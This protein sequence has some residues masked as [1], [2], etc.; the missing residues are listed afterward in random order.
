M[1][2][3]LLFLRSGSKYYHLALCFLPKTMAGVPRETH[4]HICVRR[5]NTCQEQW[6]EYQERPT[7][8]HMCV[9]RR[10][11]WKVKVVCLLSGIAG[12]VLLITVPIVPVPTK[13]AQHMLHNFSIA[14]H[15]KQKFLNYNWILK[16]C[17][18]TRRSYRVVNLYF[19]LLN[20]FSKLTTQCVLCVC[21]QK[22][23]M[24]TIKKYLLI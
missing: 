23:S 1:V 15:I 7:H 18:H 14:F 4:T 16:A 13:T 12:T 2:V 20:Q 22:A 10:N 17:R 5:R 8:T 11:T 3:L 9:R 19:K 24:Q 21:R 6:R